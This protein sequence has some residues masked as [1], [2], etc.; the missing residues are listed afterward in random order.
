MTGA[1]RGSL[2]APVRGV[3][4]DLGGTLV[5]TDTEPTTGQVAHV[6]GITLQEA[7][8]VMEAGAKRRRIAPADL[9]AHLARDFGRPHVFEQ[10]RRVLEG[11]RTRAG[12]A[13]LFPDALA[14][15]QLLRARGFALFAMTNSLGS[16]IPA[17]EPG[18][19]A[20]LDAVVYSAD[21]G[22]CKPERGAFGAVESLSGLAPHQLLHV[23]DSARAD[24]AGAVSAGWHAAYLHRPE[25]T[26]LPQMAEPPAV[27]IRTLRT[28]RHLL[29][30]RS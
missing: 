24:A 16:S 25:D 15:L 11:A 23:G 17:Q 20:L 7:R 12:S 8:E 26:R 19:H 22:F 14:V 5:V 13:R 2:W 6:L 4:F 28:L 9:A 21:T 30:A 3:C 18:F 27:T 10:L 29:P 1:E